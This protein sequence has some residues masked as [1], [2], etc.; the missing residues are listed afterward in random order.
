MQY[1]PHIL[2]SISVWWTG[3]RVLFRQPRTDRRALLWVKLH[4]FDCRQCGGRYIGRTCRSWRSNQTTRAKAL[5]WRWHAGPEKKKRGRP[6]KKRTNLALEYPSTIAC[7]LASNDLCEQQYSESDF[8]VL[9]HARTDYHWKCWRL[10]LIV[11]CNLFC[12][13]KSRMSVV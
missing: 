9:T 6:P 7:H 10:C 8:T 4:S 13:N 1:A 3:H 12:V 11:F 2:L 5:S